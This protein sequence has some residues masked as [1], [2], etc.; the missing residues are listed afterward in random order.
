MQRATAVR[1]ITEIN[2]NFRYTYKNMTK[3]DMQIMTARWYDCL[4]SYSD[5]E[6][7][8]AFRTALCR[9]SMPPTIAD[10][11]GIIDRQKRLSEPSDMALWSEIK[12][13]V[14]KI[15]R[16]VHDKDYGFRQLYE[17]K[18]IAQDLDDIYCNLREDIRAYI[19]FDSFC[20]FGAYTDEQLQ[21]ERARFLKAIPEMREAMRDKRMIEQTKPMISAGKGI[22]QLTG[23]K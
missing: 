4:K 6:V 18:G 8:G 14:R 22:Q 13:A 1:M 9:S 10:I 11:I 3:Q 12:Q 15:Q 17:L 19:D 23:G 2:V 20:A 16:T 21:F 7:E 5:E